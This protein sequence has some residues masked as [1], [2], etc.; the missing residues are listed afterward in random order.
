M[1]QHNDEYMLLS[2]G[3]RVPPASRAGPRYRN[4]LSPAELQRVGIRPGRGWL[5]RRASQVRRRVGGRRG[6]VPAQSPGIGGYTDGESYFE[7][8]FA[9]GFA[10]EDEQVL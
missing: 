3:G 7:L 2:R 9:V 5:K 6:R 10:V 4:G 1:F 8:E